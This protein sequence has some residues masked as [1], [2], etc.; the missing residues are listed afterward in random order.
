[1]QADPR[2]AGVIHDIGYR[3]YDGARLGRGYLVRS[4]F[5]QSLRG[6]YGLGRPARS[7]VMPMLLLG[8]M[9]LPA[10]IIVVV[11]VISG[12]PE[13]PLDYRDYIPVTF[14]ISAIF[15]AA[16]SPQ[17]VSRD[18][19]F[20]TVPLYFSRPL[21]VAGYVLAKY[22]AMTLALLILLGSPIL[23]MYAGAL[24]A[25]MPFWAQTRG[26]LMGLTGAALYSLVLA[27]IGLAVASATPRRGFGV[28]AIIVVI[29]VSYT[30][31]SAVEGIALVNE[32][33][34]VALY[35][36]LF[37][38]YNLV[39]STQLWMFGAAENP[40]FDELPVP[41]GWQGAVFVAMVIAVVA[42]SVGFLLLRYRKAAVK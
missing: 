8:W 36:E 19:R 42:A 1:M 35:A 40:M 6:A 21:T 41:Q 31:V 10:L 9:L 26:A 30:V 2:A 29:L 4:L 17:L 13:L 27:G 39:N 16:Q 23:V 34:D 12:A 11:A 37:T 28:A 3:H 32:R 24:L 33:E 18:L 22:S 15:V 5:S 7:K 25:D 20:R 14:Y 38:P